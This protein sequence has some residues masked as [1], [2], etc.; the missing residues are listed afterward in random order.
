MAARL[1]L[2]IVLIAAP[3][4]AQAPEAPAAAPPAA[5]GPSSLA[6]RMLAGSWGLRVEGTVVF[7]F[8]LVRSGEGWSGTWAK[9]RSFATDGAIFA[10]LGGP[11]VETRAQRGRAIG[12]W[13]ELAF[14]DERPGAVPDVFRFRLIDPERAEMIYTDTGQ[15]P[16][17]LERV[18]PGTAPGPWPAGQIYRRPGVQPGTLVSYNLG[19]RAAP[20]PRPTP[21]PVA[22]PSTPAVI[23]R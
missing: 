7:R 10:E 4:V 17:V 2:A 3:A 18:A 13:A 16:Y 20:S 11:P 14:G 12:E 1:L 6:A 19:P 5:A 21:A 9:P 22:S 8:D 23:G 15:A